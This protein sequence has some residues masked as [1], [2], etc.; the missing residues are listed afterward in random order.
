MKN[1]RA[2]AAI[3]DDAAE[4]SSSRSTLTTTQVENGF[5]NSR[6][7][8]DRIKLELASK[9]P[10][11][12]AGPVDSASTISIPAEASTSTSNKHPHPSSD[13]DTPSS[14]T[15]PEAKKVRLSGA[16]KKVLA[17]AKADLIWDQKMAAKRNRKAE[18]KALKEGGEVLPEVD[19]GGRN[20]LGGQ[21]KVSILF[22]SLIRTGI[23]LILSRYRDEHSIIELV[24]SIYVLSQLEEKFV[25]D[26]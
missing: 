20:K 26:H 24:H 25:Q 4:G 17:R 5:S 11:P 22:S 9:L 10:P 23:M 18:A 13:P 1:A 15:E 6:N 8:E 14:N 16:Q 12:S 19:D 7:E 3:D 2:M 21:N